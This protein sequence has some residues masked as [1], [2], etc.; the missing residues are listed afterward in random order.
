MWPGHLSVVLANGMHQGR[1]KFTTA[2]FSRIA[3]TVFHFSVILP[4]FNT[5][6]FFILTRHHFVRTP[7]RRVRLTLFMNFFSRL[8]GIPTTN[9]DNNLLGVVLN[10]WGLMDFIKIENRK[11]HSNSRVPTFSLNHQWDFI[12]LRTARFYCR[13]YYPLRK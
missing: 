6:E 8:V 11:F 9:E 1:A 13:L 4:E 10:L 5:A 12:L 2:A 7:V 3:L